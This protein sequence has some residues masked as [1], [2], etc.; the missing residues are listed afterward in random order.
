MGTMEG[1]PLTIPLAAV[2]PDLLAEWGYQP[3]IPRR[4]SQYE[5]TLDLR[6]AANASARMRAKK[7]RTSLVRCSHD[8]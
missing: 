6:R 3:N 7:C 4:L 1:A 2:R 8:R 5:P